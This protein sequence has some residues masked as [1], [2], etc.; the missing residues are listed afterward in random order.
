ME[1][2]LGIFQCGCVAWDCFTSPPSPSSKWSCPGD[3]TLFR[4]DSYFCEVCNYTAKI[5]V[6]HNIIIESVCMNFE[7]A[8][9]NSGNGLY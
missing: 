3:N 7:L 2:T 5:F 6:I 1:V 4:G 8:D 9:L